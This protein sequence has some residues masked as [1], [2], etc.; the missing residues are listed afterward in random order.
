LLDQTLADCALIVFCTCRLLLP[1]QPHAPT[2]AQQQ[3]QQQGAPAPAAAAAPHAANQQQQQYPGPSAFAGAAAAAGDAQQQQQQQQQQLPRVPSLNA[4]SID[5]S[6]SQQDA[7]TAAAAAA[8]GVSGPPSFVLPSPSGVTGGAFSYS[9]LSAGQLQLQTT[10]SDFAN[11]AAGA[12]SAGGAASGFT[13]G[14]V[15]RS[16]QQGS[17]LLG[18]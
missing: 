12:P 10:G 18:G 11:Y 15:D 17:G 5:V 4:L 3:Q 14:E 9:H 8:A 16:Q 7:A 13:A 6:A 2:A 1:Q